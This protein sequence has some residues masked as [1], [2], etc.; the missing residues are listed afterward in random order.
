MEPE[1]KNGEKNRSQWGAL[2]Q[3][4]GQCHAP[5]RR[6]RPADIYSADWLFQNHAWLY[7]KDFTSRRNSV[8]YTKAIILLYRDTWKVTALEPFFDC[9]DNT[10]S[11]LYPMLM[12][13]MHYLS[14]SDISL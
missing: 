6:Q 2:F 11:L 14:S 1:G 8:N 4:H 7:T 5:I 10:L 13:E 3:H 9:D 12:Y